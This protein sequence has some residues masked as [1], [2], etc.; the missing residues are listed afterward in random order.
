MVLMLVP[1]TLKTV[2]AWVSDPL[3]D[4]VWVSSG[5]LEKK[6]E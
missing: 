4:R 5:S 3:F 1:L 2:R 6:S